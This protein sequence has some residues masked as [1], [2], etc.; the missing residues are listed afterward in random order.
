MVEGAPTYSPRI[1]FTLCKEQ[2]GNAEPGLCYIVNMGTPDV[3][4]ITVF[5][6][7]E[8][9]DRIH[10]VDQYTES[11]VYYSQSSKMTNEEYDKHFSTIYNDNLHYLEEA[12]EMYGYNNI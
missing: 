10:H 9:K 3:D 4:E 5:G 11:P 7:G 1:R 2:F 12:Q 6:R 8:D